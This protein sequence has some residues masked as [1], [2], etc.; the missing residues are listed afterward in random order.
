ME[1]KTS[2]LCSM[3]QLD[4]ENEF[5]RGANLRGRGRAV[6]ADHSDENR[7]NMND[8]IE[9]NTMST[10][11]ELQEVHGYSNLSALGIRAQN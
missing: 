4:A 11:Q 9:L 10:S 7:Q 2:D 3:E 8:G 6:D 5:D 1:E